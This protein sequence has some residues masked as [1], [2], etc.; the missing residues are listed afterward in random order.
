MSKCQVIKEFTTYY[1]R[2]FARKILSIVIEF[3]P[4][5]KSQKQTLLYIT[6]TYT[7]R[8]YIGIIYKVDSLLTGCVSELFETFETVT[9]FTEKIGILEKM[10]SCF[11]D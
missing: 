8:T 1:R 3:F 2:L 9:S 4:V 5:D 6:T 7:V 11:G 10:R